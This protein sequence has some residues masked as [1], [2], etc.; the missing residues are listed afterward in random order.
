MRPLV[1]LLLVAPLA[2]LAARV[3]PDWIA[4]QRAPGPVLLCEAA[5]TL[6]RPPLEVQACCER[7]GVAPAEALED[8]PDGLDPAAGAARIFGTVLDGEERPLA[9]ATLALYAPADVEPELRRSCRRNWIEGGPARRACALAFSG[10]DGSFEFTCDPRLEFR[11]ALED[12]GAAHAAYFDPERVRA[13]AQSLRFVAERSTLEV[14]MRGLAPEDAGRLVAIDRAAIQSEGAPP[15]QFSQGDAAWTATVTPGHVYRLAWFAPDRPLVW[16][17]VA[18]V[19]GATRTYFEFDAPAPGPSGELHVRVVDPESQPVAGVHRI[20][21]AALDPRVELQE[22]D[23]AGEARLRLPPGRFL[24]SLLSSD[25][26]ARDYVGIAAECGVPAAGASTLEL[27]L[28]PTGRLVVR[29]RDGAAAD[30]DEAGAAV[31]R[32]LH[33]RLRDGE[34]RESPLCFWASFEPGDAAARRPDDPDCCC[35]PGPPRTWSLEPQ[36]THCS[37]NAVA[38]GAYTLLCEGAR[39]AARELPIVVRADAPTEVVLDL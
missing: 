5:P 14:V 25:F 27:V 30:G 32:A 19:P 17:E 6:A 35:L 22:Q 28:P 20:C 36:G 21:I 9:Y 3:A 8:A 24:V 31:E 29:F 7:V 12:A 15:L 34:G 39:G 38:A 23:I 26:E 11:L 1:A 13:N 4:A 18:V 16:H 10:E 33:F 37:A 2:C